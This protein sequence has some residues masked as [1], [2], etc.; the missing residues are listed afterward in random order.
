M[1]SKDR[2]HRVGLKD[3][4]VTTYYFIHSADSVD[5]VVYERVLEKEN[6]MLELIESQD[7]PLLSNIDFEENSEADIKAIIRDYYERRNRIF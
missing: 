5:H 7:I 6:R 1:Q 3:T 4:D 2:I